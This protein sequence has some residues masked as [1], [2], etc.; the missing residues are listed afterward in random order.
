MAYPKCCVCGSRFK[1]R[2]RNRPKSKRRF[3]SA[4][5][6]QKWYESR[7][8]KVKCPRCGKDFILNQ[9]GYDE[10]RRHCSLKCGNEARQHVFSDE[11]IRERIMPRIKKTRNGCWLYV[12]AGGGIKPNPTMS[13]KRVSYPVTALIVKLETGL[14][15][16]TIVKGSKMYCRHCGNRRCVNP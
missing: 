10:G 12:G 16:I 13:F 9:Y 11:F 4:E 6:R 3:C 2:K 15:K 1:A 8:L 7:N 14:D 5:C